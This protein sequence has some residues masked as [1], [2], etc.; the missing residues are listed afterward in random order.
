MSSSSADNE[1]GEEEKDTGDVAVAEGS[2]TEYEHRQNDL[3]PG[4]DHIVQLLQEE[5]DSPPTPRQATRTNRYKAVQDAGYGSEE[6]SSENL[7]RRPGSPP[8][9]IMSNPD[10]TPSVQVCLGCLWSLIYSNTCTGFL[11]L[12]SSW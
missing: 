3:E 8:E 6:G 2:V 4:E 9:S 12:I 7:P 5:R 11:Y 1:S 10:D